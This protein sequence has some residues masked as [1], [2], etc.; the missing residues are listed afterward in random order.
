[1]SAYVVSHDHIDALLTF[2]V[3]QRVTFPSAEGHS[4]TITRDNATEIGQILL[5][6]NILSVAHR[7]AQAADTGPADT[8]RFRPWIEAP[9]ALGIMKGCS[10]LDYQ[11]CERPD[12]AFTMAYRIICA[13]RDWA[14]SGLPGW[15]DAPGWSFSRPAKP[16]FR[17]VAAS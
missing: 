6:R 9:S 17:V 16:R 15:S 1:M 12:W 4:I 8:Y 3:A 5:M 13:I 2:A 7:Y 11:S 14:C 10:S